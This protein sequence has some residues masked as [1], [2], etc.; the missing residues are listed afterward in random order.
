MLG[1]N[2]IFKALQQF[3]KSHK[4]IAFDPAKHISVFPTYPTL[5]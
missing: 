5:N 1:D 3:E 2:R 4:F